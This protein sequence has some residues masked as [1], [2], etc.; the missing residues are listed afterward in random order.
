ML[1]TPHAQNAAGSRVTRFVI[2][3]IVNQL[4]AANGFSTSS[5]P[6]KLHCLAFGPQIISTAI[7]TLNQMQTAGNVTDNLPGYTIIDGN[8]A[9]IVSAL[10]I[11]I[12]KILEDGVQV[13]LIQ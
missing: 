9:A 3:S 4:A 5:K 6:F 10:Q 8:A 1:S 12:A 7:N 2:L 11:A 13:S